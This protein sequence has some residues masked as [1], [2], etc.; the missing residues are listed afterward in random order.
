MLQ[1]SSQNDQR[2]R[3]QDIDHG[4][5]TELIQMVR[6]DHGVIMFSPE[7]VGPGFELDQVINMSPAVCRPIHAA[8]DATEWKSTLRVAASQ[9]L[10][11]L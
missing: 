2:V 9:L 4:I 5:A 7:I 1:D 11:D 3:P 10:E 6:A 8:H